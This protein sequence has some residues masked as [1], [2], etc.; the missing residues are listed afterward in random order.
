MHDQHAIQALIE[1]LASARLEHVTE[2]RIQAAAVFSPEALQ[3]AYEMLTRETPLAGS[4]LVVAEWVHECSCPSCGRSWR[5]GRED[6]EGHVV[7]CPS[8][9]AICPIERGAGIEVIGIT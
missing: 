8:C 4:R 7:I 5:V 3:Q 9:G 6:V 2:V 1:R